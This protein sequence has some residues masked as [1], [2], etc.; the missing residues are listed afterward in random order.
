M[1]GSAGPGFV[2]AESVSNLLETFPP[3]RGLVLGLLL[4][5]PSIEE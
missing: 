1:A 2:G 4:L 5:K 3:P